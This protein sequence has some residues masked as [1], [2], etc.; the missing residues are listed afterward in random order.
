MTWL[1]RSGKAKPSKHHLSKYLGG[2]EGVKGSE[3]YV[4]G[5]ES[6]AHTFGVG[7][8]SSSGRILANIRHVYKPKEGGIHPREAAQ[9]HRQRASTASKEAVS[10][11][12]VKPQDFDGVAFS[13]GPR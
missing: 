4:L 2:L 7:V 12:G 10:R 3:K 13:I 1:R 5:I 11:S 6:T 8:A 9:Q